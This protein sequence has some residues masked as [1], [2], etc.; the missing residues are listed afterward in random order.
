MA[1]TPAVSLSRTTVEAFEGFSV[2]ELFI[3]RSPESSYQRRHTPSLLQSHKPQN[4]EGAQDF[5]H[6]KMANST[7]RAKL[8]LPSLSIPNYRLFGLVV[9]LVKDTLCSSN[10]ALDCIFLHGHLSIEHQH[11]A[12]CLVFCA[13]KGPRGESCNFHS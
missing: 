9:L 6:S 10:F 7:H 3:F 1:R 4:I 2:L 11:V 13:T 12:T 5:G 8:V